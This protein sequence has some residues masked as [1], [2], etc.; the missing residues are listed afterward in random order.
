MPRVDRMNAGREVRERLLEILRPYGSAWSGAIARGD[1]VIPQR[2][3]PKLVRE[4]VEVL[5]NAS[6]QR[7]ADE[8]EVF[9]ALMT[10]RRS[11]SVQKQAAQLVQRFRIFTRDS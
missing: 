6:G 10:V 4:I 1:L 2:E 3:I 7:E 8:R 11:A 9:D 5:Q